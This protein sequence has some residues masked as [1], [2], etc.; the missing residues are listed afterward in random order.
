MV[1]IFLYDFLL[2]VRQTIYV[3]N[4]TML[5]KTYLSSAEFPITGGMEL[6]SFKVL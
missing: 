5:L 3:E 4:I 6:S 2:G 1:F